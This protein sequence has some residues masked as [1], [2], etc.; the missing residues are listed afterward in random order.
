[1]SS[2]QMNRDET[3]TKWIADLK[4]RYFH[5]QIKASIVVNSELL[6]YY[7]QLGRDIVHMQAENLY[8]SDFYNML[9]KDLRRELPSAKGF[10]QANLRYMKRFYSLFSEK[11]QPGN[12]PQVVEDFRQKDNREI[13]LVPWGHIRGRG[14]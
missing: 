1:M 12:L 7:W 11:S 3:Y 14:G 9:S 10:S 2:T 8:G 4:S 5:S 13:F 6:S